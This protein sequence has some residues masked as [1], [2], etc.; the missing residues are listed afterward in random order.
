MSLFSIIIVH[1]FLTVIGYSLFGT[2]VNRHVRFKEINIA[3]KNSEE[4]RAH[5]PFIY[6]ASAD[7]S[8]ISF[9]SGAILTTLDQIFFN[10]KYLSHIQFDSTFKTIFLFFFVCSIIIMVYFTITDYKKRIKI[11]VIL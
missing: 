11:K 2:A 9:I 6:N 8:V 10:S 7:I 5:F 1:F 3:N 4:F